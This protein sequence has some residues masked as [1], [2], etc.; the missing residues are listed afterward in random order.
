MGISGEGQ[1]QLFQAFGQV[2]SSA[3]RRHGGTGLGLAISKQLVETMGG[4]IGL[5]STLGSGSTFWF[6]VELPPA[7]APEPRLSHEVSRSK[8]VDR[9]RPHP[10]PAVGARV[11]VAED[12]PVNQLVAT[13]MLE[14]LGYRADVAGNGAEAVEALM[15]IDYALVLMDCQ[16]PELDGFEATREIR[17]RQTPP[18]RTPVIA[19]TAAATPSDRDRCYEADMDD[20]ISKPVRL[21]EL[22]DVLAR[23]LPLTPAVAVDAIPSGS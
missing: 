3:T 19:M 22:G 10:T 8:G 20:Y 13:R 18:R 15:T 5:E 11:L 6:T 12:N 17:R 9:S 7:T 1:R 2:D 23:W 4:E 14:K 21:G 16:M